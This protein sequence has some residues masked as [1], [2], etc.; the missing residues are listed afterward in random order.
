MRKKV[1]FVVTSILLGIGSWHFT[2]AIRI[3]NNKIFLYTILV[4]AYWIVP[5]FFLALLTRWKGRSPKNVGITISIFWSV[6]II[7]YYMY[8]AYLITI[9]GLPQLEELKLSNIKSPD[10]LPL[11]SMIARTTFI[12]QTTKWLAGA[13]VGGF[14]FGWIVGILYKLQLGQR[15]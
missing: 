15:A 3:F 1:L 13:S 7:S 5:A 2:I 6:A 9:P 10:F 11:W 14:I 8:Y 12:P 4:Y